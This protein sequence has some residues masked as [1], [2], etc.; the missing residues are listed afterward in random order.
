M[1]VCIEEKKRPRGKGDKERYGEGK[2]E[3][4]RE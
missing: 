2:K 4:Y 3:R 1:K